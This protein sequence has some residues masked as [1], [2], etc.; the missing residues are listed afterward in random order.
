MLTRSD[1]VDLLQELDGLEQQR[2]HDEHADDDG[3]ERRQ[4]QEP[5][6]AGAPCGWRAGSPGEERAGLPG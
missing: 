6:D 4:H 3:H 5:R 2:E 1:E